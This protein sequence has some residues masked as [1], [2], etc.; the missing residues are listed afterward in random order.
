MKRAFFLL[1]SFFAFCLG[2]QAQERLPYVIEPGT[3]DC[4]TIYTLPT[5]EAVFEGGN[6]AMYDFYFDKL[7]HSADLLTYMSSNL[8]LLKILVNSKGE[9]V[10]SKV[11]RSFNSEYGEDVK[12]V[13]DN[14]FPVLVPAQ[15]EGRAVCSY[16]IL[17]LYFK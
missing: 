13:T 15:Y 14:G 9:L 17:K 6:D 5:S 4:D 11:L 8:V 2:S 1:A 3:A 10:S 7:K 12:T 16:R